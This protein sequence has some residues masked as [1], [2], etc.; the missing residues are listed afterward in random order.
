M[1]DRVS[2]GAYWGV[3]PLTITQAVQQALQVFEGLS[4]IHELLSL[5][6][7]YEKGMSKKEALSKQLVLSEGT[8]RR[9]LQD[10]RN[11]Y[12]TT[13]EIIEDLGYSF[14]LWNGRDDEDGVSLNMVNGV[15]NPNPHLNNFCVLSTI[16]TSSALF[17]SETLNLILTAL[18]ETL[19]PDWGRVNPWIS[20]LDLERTTPGVGWLTYL[21][22]A[23][24]PIP[25]L[26]SG[27]KVTFRPDHSTLIQLSE[28]LFDSSVP[29]HIKRIQ[30]TTTALKQAGIVKPV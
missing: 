17:K 11:R 25:S 5:S 16:K 10:G 28:E 9:L 26:P 7:W 6:T 1:P 29:E 30:E 2:I 4:R 23:Y 24:Q 22:P 13:D 18:I 15:T 19:Q 20:E 12:D 3:R 27:I 21:S 8:M 14:N